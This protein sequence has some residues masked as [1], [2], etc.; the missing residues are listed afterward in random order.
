MALC[1]PSKPNDVIK[2]K[3]Y[4][5]IQ[6]LPL[7]LPVPAMGNDFAKLLDTYPVTPYLDSQPAFLKWMHFVHNKVNARLGKPE[8]SLETAMVNYYEFYKPKTVQNVEAR[9]RRE[10]IVFLVIL[11]TALGFCYALA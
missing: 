8:I 2:K 11:G 7:F 4:D 10:K 9:R 5:F 3:Y 1:Y 6:N